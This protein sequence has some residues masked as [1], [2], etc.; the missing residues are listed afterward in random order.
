MTNNSKKQHSV[1]VRLHTT[2]V[3]EYR[4]VLRQIYKDDDSIE[5]VKIPKE[6]GLGVAFSLVD[7]PSR[8]DWANDFEALIGYDYQIPDNKYS[9]AVVVFKFVLSKDEV[10]FMSVTFGHGESLLDNSKFENDFGRVIA[11]QKVPESGIYSAGTMQIS[12]TI[13]QMEKQYAGSRSGGIGRLVASSSEF[14]NNISGLW[15]SGAVETRL[16]GGSSLLKSTRLMSLEEVYA[17][18]RGYLD[19]YLSPSGMAD[20]ATRLAR[21]DNSSLKDKLD[22]VL[23]TNMISQQS[24]YGLAWPTYRDLRNIS[25]N[26]LKQMPEGKTPVEQL[27]WYIQKRV[28][29]KQ[30]FLPKQLK[31][32]LRSSK[33]VAVDTDGE[34][35]SVG[36]YRCLY[37]EQIY[38]GKRYL[39]FTGTWYEVAERFYKDIQKKL[40]SVPCYEKQLPD[41]GQKEDGGEECEGNYNKRLAKFIDDAV[42]F[43][44]DD[45][46]NDKG[47]SFRGPEEPADVI[48]KRKELFFV[49]KGTASAALSHLFLQGLVSAKLIAKGGDTKM[50][51]FVNKKFKSENDVF[52]DEVANSDITLIFVIIK[53]NRQLPFFSMV[54]FSEVVD[55][56]RSMEYQVKVAWVSKTSEVTQR[57]ED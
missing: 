26:I 11:A 28:A 25:T 7:Q 12:D 49:K 41:L 21:V 56:L 50:R 42:L 2:Q 51:D 53:N 19:A 34:N 5:E 20:W 48:T 13:I 38:E 6:Y 55:N 40:N 44:T 39:L 3:K 29:G 35:V 9:K 57:S 18:L 27:E 31:N 22:D 8:P 47:A 24:T 14:P 15:K 30:G 46:N 37:S 4:D 16:D 54:S 10:R 33:M 52:S 36:L 17:D 45:F 43:D 1:S 23:M 32:K